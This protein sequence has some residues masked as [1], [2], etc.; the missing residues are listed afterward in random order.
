MTTAFGAM[1]KTR[2]R[3]GRFGLIAGVA[4]TTTIA[5]GCVPADVIP[6]FPK[7]SNGDR[8]SIEKSVG[9]VDDHGNFA[10]SRDT[11]PLVGQVIAYRVKLSDHGQSNTTVVDTVPAG[12]DLDVSSIRAR[13]GRASYDSASRSITW[14]TSTS[15]KSKK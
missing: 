15:N 5:T 12:L 4:M 7:S 8:P 1:I 13:P 14:T 11:Q 6:K 3:R 10:S 9:F 2:R